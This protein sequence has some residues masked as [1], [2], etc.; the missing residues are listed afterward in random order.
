MTKLE[1]YRRR[2]AEIFGT[3]NPGKKVAADWVELYLHFAGTIGFDAA[4]DVWFEANPQMMSIC[5]R[6]QLGDTKD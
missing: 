3:E 4:A 6:P 2:S 1:L 5:S